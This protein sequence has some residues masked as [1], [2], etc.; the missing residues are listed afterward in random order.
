MGSPLDTPTATLAAFVADSDPAAVPA[1]VRHEATRSL[2]NVLGC[3]L[4]GADDAA[5][6][7][8]W[9]TL[10]PF[11]GAPTAT[12]LGTG[13]R[14]DALTAALVNGYASNI[15]DF[16]DTHLTTVIHPGPPVFSALLALA[17]SINAGYA[18]GAGTAAAGAS[19]VA[20]PVRGADLLYAFLLGMEVACRVGVAIG[21]GHYARGWHITGTCGVLGAAAG[22]ARLLGLDAARTSHA[23]G[24][25]ATQ[26]GGLIEMLGGMSKTFN[27]ARA[28]REGLAA[29]LLAAR[30]FT[31]STRALEAPRGFAHVL[32]DGL[33]HAALLGGLG[34]RWEAG[35]NTYK[36]YPC[37]I[38]LHPLIDACLQLAR[39]HDI[40]PA[41]IEVVDTV[42]H[43]LVLKLT[44]RTDPQ[45]G[46]ASKLSYTHAAAVALVERAAGPAQFT[47]ACA[48]DPRVVAQ[49]GRVKA[50]EDASLGSD[51]VEVT[52]RLRD[53]RALH[54]RI[55]HA[56]GSLDNPLTDAA[57]S[58]KFRALADPVLGADRAQQVLDQC[59]QIDALPDAGALA[60][61][62]ATP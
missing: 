40:D 31:S 13:E 22:A 14:S 28:G 39:A 24:I 10:Q 59:W 58:E 46:L 3:A 4:G 29:A 17:E 30:G 57:L 25:A 51:Q 33:D 41:Q 42:V 34:E 56:T 9:S 61:A 6:R 48:V 53:G 16:D 27:I 23:L 36:P 43:P 26:A 38:V 18:A 44:W 47:D 35:S 60:R 52:L 11:A 12:L 5:T 2:V 32:A 45:D 20:Q 49:R 55:E 8:L 19:A 62:C 54:C 50:A 21:P 7:L 15:L 1:T 37:G